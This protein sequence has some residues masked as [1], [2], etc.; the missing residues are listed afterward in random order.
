MQAILWGTTKYTY[1]NAGKHIIGK[2]L[3]LAELKLISAG[4]GGRIGVIPCCSVDDNIYHI[5]CDIHWQ[6]KGKSGNVV[7]DLGGGVKKDQRPYDALYQE[8]REEVPGWHDILKS[9]IEHSPVQIY[10]IEYMHASPHELRY[11]ITIFVDITPYIK[12]LND[13]FKPTRE[14]HGIHAH[15]DLIHTITTIENL[16]YGLMY[17]RDY[18]T[19]SFYSQHKAPVVLQH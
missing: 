15:T 17:Y 8:L 10:S 18:L 5:L 1:Q 19:Y 11:S 4:Y 12:V 3:K 2:E 16:N 13:M 9:Q 14:I 7:G 6:N